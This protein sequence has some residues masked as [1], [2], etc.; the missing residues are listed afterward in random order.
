MFRSGPSADCELLGVAG[1]GLV[2]VSDC[3]EDAWDWAEE[4][5]TDLLLFRR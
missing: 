1:S 5:L 2:V 4:L 3:S